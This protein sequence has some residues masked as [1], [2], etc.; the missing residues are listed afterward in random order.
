MR[1]HHVR[2]CV[3]VPRYRNAFLH[4][5][6]DSGLVHYVDSVGANSVVHS[7][8]MISIVFCICT[9]GGRPGRIMGLHLR[10]PRFVRV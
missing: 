9:Q 3:G 5:D 10:D 1:S 8:S 4:F 2:L 6:C 7:F